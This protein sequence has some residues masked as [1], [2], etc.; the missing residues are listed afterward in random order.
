MTVEQVSNSTG[1][2]AFDDLRVHFLTLVKCPRLYAVPHKPARACSTRRFLA[3]CAI[4]QTARR[5]VEADRKDKKVVYWII[6]YKFHSYVKF[7]KRA[8]GEWPRNTA[9]RVV[10]DTT[11]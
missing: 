4:D 2:Y 11:T 10:S 9:P 3:R 1:L 7:P 5:P 6:P 8:I